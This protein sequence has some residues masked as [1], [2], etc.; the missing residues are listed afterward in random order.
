MANLVEFVRIK[1]IIVF[2]VSIYCSNSLYRIVCILLKYICLNDLSP[3][4]TK[5]NTQ[6]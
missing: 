5:F 4:F 1:L 2:I 3:E 6:L